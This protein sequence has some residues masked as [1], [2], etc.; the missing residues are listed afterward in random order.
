MRCRGRILLALVLVEVLTRC[1]HVLLPSLHTGYITS[2]CDA[3]SDVYNSHHY[4]RTPE[5]AVAAV[6]H[7][8]TDIDCTSFVGQ[9]AQARAG[10]F[11]CRMSRVS[12]D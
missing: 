8:G 7:A 6:L 3:D 4:T 9:H 12:A 11:K 5:E 10:E 2:D 1:S